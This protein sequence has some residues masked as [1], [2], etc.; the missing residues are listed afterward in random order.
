MQSRIRSALASIL[1]LA[2]LT[3]P[4]FAQDVPPSGEMSLL[5]FQRVAVAGGLNYDWHYGSDLNPE[6]AFKKEVAGGLYG[7]Y[8]LTPHLSGYTAVVYGVDN[9]VWRISPGLHYRMKAGSEF[10]ALALTYDY[11]AGNIPQVPFY[12]HEWAVAVSYARPIGKNLVIG[13]TES[14]GMDNRMWR[15]SVGIRIPLFLGKDS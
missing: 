15:T 10:F 9:R 5:N 12:S 1:S 14:Y 11:Y 6:P 13:A 7:A 4:A 3:A 2:F 8:V